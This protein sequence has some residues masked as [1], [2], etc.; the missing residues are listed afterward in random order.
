MTMF[1]SIVDD[2]IDKSAAFANPI[3]TLAAAYS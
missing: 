3:N 1:N 2:Y